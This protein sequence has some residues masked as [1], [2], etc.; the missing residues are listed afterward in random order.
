MKQTNEL[1]L[2]SA[3]V[4]FSRIGFADAKV[5]TVAQN[6][7]LTKITIFRHFE[8]KERLF[9]AVID[10]YIR[11]A[12]PPELPDLK[13]LP[14]KDGLLKLCMSLILYMFDH[15]H[16]LRIEV[17][18]D[19]LLEQ[20]DGHFRKVIEGIIYS[21]LEQFNLSPFPDLH[22]YAEMLACQVVC[23]ALTNNK[24]GGIWTPDEAFLSSV[25]TM[26]RKRISFLL[27]KL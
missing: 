6:C 27:W 19:G 7:G 10:T 3:L 25:D 4:E 1:I 8:S 20:E 26:L 17:Q 21:Y 11:N 12:E 15:I 14:L 9:Q 5:E 2:E 13:G 24:N 16:A 18:A 23:V 22:F